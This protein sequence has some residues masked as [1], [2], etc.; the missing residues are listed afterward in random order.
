MH[1]THAGPGAPRGRSAA[2]LNAG[3]RI[4]LPAARRSQP[5]LL[6]HAAEAQPPTVRAGSRSRRRAQACLAEVLGIFAKLP[7]GYQRDY[8]SSTATVPRQIDLALA[9]AASWPLPSTAGVSAPTRSNSTRD[10]RRRRSER[11]GLRARHP[12]PRAIAASAR[13]IASDAKAPASPIN[14]GSINDGY[15]VRNPTID[16]VRRESVGRLSSHLGIEF[17]EWGD[18]ICAHHAGGAAHCAN[19]GV[20]ARRRI[21]RAGRNPR[22]VAANFVV[23]PDRFRCWG[24]TSTPITCAG[25][26]RPRV[27]ARRAR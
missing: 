11:A 21:P 7:S 13:N 4:R 6:D 27:S 9:T 25:H 18:D 26:R 2:V 5:P 14:L 22:S 20:S 8:S 1:A 16:D 15:L 10:S 12:V 3:V 19:H 24:R 23:D 17:T